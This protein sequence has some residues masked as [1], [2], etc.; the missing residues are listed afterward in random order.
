MPREI[1]I[2]FTGAMVREVL[3]GRKTMTRR[4]VKRPPPDDIAATSIRCDHYHPTIIDRRG[5]EQPGPETFGAFDDYGEWGCPCPYGAPGD[6]LWVRETWR[7]PSGFPPGV[8]YRA[9]NLLRAFDGNEP[10][11]AHAVEPTDRWRPSIFMP[12]W[13]SRL[14]LD[15]LSV[16]VERVQDIGDADVAAEGV[17]AESV[18]ALWEGATR[19]ARVG[20]TGPDDASPVVPFD[21]MAPYFLWRIAWTLINGRASWDSDP[22]VWVVEF[23]R[24]QEEEAS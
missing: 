22:W 18:A 15:V 12:R 8:Q 14:T 3:A 16:R 7:V 1:P 10:A 5:E 24:A 11:E 4:M 19:K 2:L 23:R 9:S 21:R 6:R 20:F 17:T 13:A